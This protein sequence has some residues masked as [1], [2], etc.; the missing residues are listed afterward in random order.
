M[1]RY[2]ECY[3]L[4]NYFLC[5]IY[6]RDNNTLDKYSKLNVQGREF[7]DISNA[8]NYLKNLKHRILEGKDKIVTPGYS[9]ENNNIK[10]TNDVF[11]SYRTKIN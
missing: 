6:T 8:A 9:Y 4:N 2:N 10:S 1:Q 7:N 11:H 5:K 3:Q